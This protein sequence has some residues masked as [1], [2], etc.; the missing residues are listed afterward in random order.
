MKYIPN[1]SIL[2][3]CWNS[4]RHQKYAGLAWVKLVPRIRE[5]RKSQ[6]RDTKEEEEVQNGEDRLSTLCV[7]EKHST[8]P[9]LVAL[10]ASQ[11]MG[12]TQGVPFRT[13]VWYYGIQTNRETWSPLPCKS[14]AQTTKQ[15]DTQTDWQ[16]DIDTKQSE[17]DI[18]TDTHIT[19]QRPTHP[20]F[21]YEPMQTW[22][23]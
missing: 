22:N 23:T 3:R 12:D 15:T 2:T 7:K 9:C 18:Q 21:Q 19:R 8:S 4:S 17:T 5:N 13:L 14:R 1:T 6:A 20:F 16:T 11:T 10:V